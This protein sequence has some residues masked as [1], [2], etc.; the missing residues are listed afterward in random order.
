M[1]DLWM[2]MPA[3]ILPGMIDDPKIEGVPIKDERKNEEKSLYHLKTCS[4]NGGG[5]AKKKKGLNNV[6]Y[7]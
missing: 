5:K 4:E 2:F 1:N 7:R 3:F 6:M